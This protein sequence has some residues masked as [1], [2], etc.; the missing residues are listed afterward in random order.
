[1]LEKF[2]HWTLAQLADV[3]DAQF[4]AVFG[5]RDDVYHSFAEAAA[6][7]KAKREAGHGG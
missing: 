4:A 7:L 6:S 5:E 3:P 1:M 2:P